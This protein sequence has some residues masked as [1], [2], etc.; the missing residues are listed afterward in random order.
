[1]KNES[2]LKPVGRAV[3]L[4]PY[5]P[6]RAKSVIEL[7]SEVETNEQVKEQRAI[8]VEAGPAAW[9]EEIKAGYGPR[10]EP[11]DKV[12]IAGYTGQMFKGTADGKQYRIVNDRDIFT[13]IE[14]ENNG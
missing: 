11:G 4:M 5:E 9:A 2:G 3:L 14:V 7:P 10:A 13:K 12:L 1:M 6:E 8:V